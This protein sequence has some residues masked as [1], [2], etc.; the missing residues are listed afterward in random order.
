VE[1]QKRRGALVAVPAMIRRFLARV[2]EAA[3]DEALAD[4][5]DM[6]RRR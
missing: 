1:K 3:T 6:D 5:I 2:R 4:V